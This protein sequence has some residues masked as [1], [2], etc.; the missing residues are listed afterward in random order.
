MLLLIPLLPFVGFLINATVGRRLMAEFQLDVDTAT[1]AAV[2][3]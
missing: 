2:L 3:A 1:H